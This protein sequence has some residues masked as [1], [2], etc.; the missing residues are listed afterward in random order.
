MSHAGA[1]ILVIEDENA[2]REGLVDNLKLEGYDVLWRANG[3][4]GVEAYEQ[5]KPDLVILD[6][7][8]PEMDGLEVCRR[9]R[10][11]MA[12]TPIIML[13]AKASEVDKV[14]GL[15]LGADDY[16][17]KPFGMRE[18]FARV[19]ALLR[20]TNGAAQQQP[21]ESKKE[22][23]DDLS[24][25]T[26]FIDFRTY[27]AR[28]GDQEIVLSAKEF[29]LLRYLSSQPDVP[30]TR[31]ELLDNVWGYNNY[32]S[33]RTVDNFI[34]RL[35]QKIEENSEKPRHIVTVHGVGYKFVQ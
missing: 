4:S 30:V 19:K 18:L 17:T 13:T 31:D 11:S 21:E 3:K 7:M 25:G 9:I 33:T 10:S 15:E 5:E 1:K 6:L 24:F 28:K 34:A 29:E 26:V 20:R 14:V 35:R 16:L 23:R 27:R 12:G 8:M 2:V 32:P 22:M